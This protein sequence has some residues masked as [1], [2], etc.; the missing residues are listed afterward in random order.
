MPMYDYRCPSC[1]AEFEYTN[2]VA[3]RKN[4]PCPECEQTAEMI[5]V[6][7][8]TLDP[9]MGVDPDFPGMAAKWDKKQRLKATGKMKDHNNHRYNDGQDLERDAHRLRKIYDS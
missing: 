9:R 1:G 3:E 5:I 4:A 7:A 8:P 2:K 6:A